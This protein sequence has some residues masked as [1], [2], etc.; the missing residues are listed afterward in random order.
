MDAILKGLER[1][2]P[3]LLAICLAGSLGAG[4]PGGVTPI[5]KLEFLA[6]QDGV[7]AGQ[8]LQVAVRVS[9]AGDFHVNSH[10]PSTEYLIPTS[11]DLVAPEG[12]AAKTWDFPEGTNKRFPYSDV[13]LSVYEGTFVVR[14]SLKVAEGTAPGAKQARG[15][16]KYQACTSQRCYPPKKEEVTLQF[17][18]VPPG[19]A[20][21]PLHPELFTAVVH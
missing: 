7:Q 14:G 15:M 19:T 4:Q 2:L 13:P 20:D 9:L 6:G 21:Q 16:L 3:W 5:K 18:V 17:R 11:F 8:Q 10:V 1:R 12:F